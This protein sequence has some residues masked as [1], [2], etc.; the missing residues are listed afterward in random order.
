MPK[1][2]DTG[3]PEAE[4]HPYRE[5]DV[6]TCLDAAC[7]CRFQLEPGDW[8]RRGDAADRDDSDK[9]TAEV[10]ADCPLC[11]SEAAALIEDDGVPWARQP[12]PLPGPEPAPATVRAARAEGAPK[13]RPQPAGDP[14]LF[15]L[16]PRVAGE[17]PFEDRVDR[18]RV[19]RESFV[20]G[21]EVKG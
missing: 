13:R 14:G 1:I 8:W 6:L 16:K 7:G 2:I 17:P 12:A 9:P 20:D 21:V 11:A 3:I 19:E 18:Q 4:R 15:K 10:R 5:G